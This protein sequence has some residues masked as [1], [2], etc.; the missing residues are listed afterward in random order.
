MEDI[1]S[2]ANNLLSKE[3]LLKYHNVEEILIGII[4]LL[5]ALRAFRASGFKISADQVKSSRI[6]LVGASFII[7]GSSSLIHALIHA[8][9]S[10]LNLL[11]HKLLT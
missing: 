1:Y 4:C 11:Y 5:I 10:D 3:F 6:F 8:T 7:L 9:H 2:V